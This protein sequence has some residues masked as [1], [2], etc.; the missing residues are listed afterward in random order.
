MNTIKKQLDH[1]CDILAYHSP[2]PRLDAE[3]LLAFVLGK[4]RSY[5]RAWDDKELE[6]V[7]LELF[8]I[9]GA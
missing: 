4:N 9:P 6:L 3:V 2:S 1:A 8:I 5:L 7:S